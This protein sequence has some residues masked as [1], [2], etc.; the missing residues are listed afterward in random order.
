MEKFPNIVFLDI[1]GVLNSQLF[2]QE[3]FR[4]RSNRDTIIT[5]EEI[6]LHDNIDKKAVSFLNN[7]CKDIDAKVVISSTWRKNRTVEDLQQLFKIVGGTFDIIDKTLFL[8]MSH[9]AIGTSIPRGFEIEVW[10]RSNINFDK[11]GMYPYQFQRY[12]I[13]DDDSDMLYVQRNNFFQTDSYCGLTP[14]ICYY[15]V[16]YF[17]SFEL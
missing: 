16:Q 10:L 14:N 7:L 9:L 17:K 11:H 3:R 8:D 5:D 13:L 15:I 2:Y 6:Y 12:V 4:E 1:D